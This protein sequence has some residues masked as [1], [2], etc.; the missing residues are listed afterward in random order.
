MISVRQIVSLICSCKRAKK[1][2]RER[3]KKEEEKKKRKKEG[4]KRLVKD[5]NTG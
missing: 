3:G 4:E 1:K 2:K 5:L